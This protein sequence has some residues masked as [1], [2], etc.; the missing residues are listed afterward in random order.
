MME[1]F[2]Y[3]QKWEEKQKNSHELLCKAVR[4]YAAACRIPLPDQLTLAGTEEGGKPYFANAPGVFFSISHS[5]ELWAC[6]IAPQEVGLDIQKEQNCRAERLAKRFFHPEEAKWLEKKGYD[7]FCRLWAYKES[8]VKYMGT[9]LKNG[10]DYFNVIRQEED[11]PGMEHPWQ[12]EVDFFPDC[13]MAV[14]CPEKARIVL[15]AM[16]AEGKCWEKSVNEK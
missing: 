9:G 14:T 16:P 10:L 11:V 2:V 13:R 4:S 3:W 5:K 7:Q 15:L 6:A 12:C 8:Y 1:V